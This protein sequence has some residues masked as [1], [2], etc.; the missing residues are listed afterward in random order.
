MRV[1]IIGGTGFVGRYLVDALLDSGHSISLLVRQGSES[2]LQQPEKVHLVHG[3]LSSNESILRVLEGCDAAIYNVGILREVPRKGITFESTQY[4]GL[5][6]TV[7]AALAVGVPRLLLMSA[8][9]VKLPGTRYQETKLHAEEYALNSG[10]NVTVFRPSVIFGD[11][12][13]SMEFATQLFNEMVRPPIPALSFFSGKDL[14]QG[15]VVMSP[16]HV[17]DVASAFLAA[18][19][20]N[21][22]VGKTYALGGP[23]ILTWKEM[24]SRIAAATGRRKWFLPMPIALM[25]L[26]APISSDARPTEHA[27]RGQRRRCGSPEIA[28]W[29]RADCILR[30]EPGVPRQVS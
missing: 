3:D 28:Y 11:P 21:E 17:N 30:R 29:Q 4:H 27:G 20:N 25:R 8:N 2:K 23:E 24:V 9:G 22:C 14:K 1:A 7:D 10:L 16:V 5:V 26:V 12:Q 6:S 15:A 18:L 13:G 19:Q